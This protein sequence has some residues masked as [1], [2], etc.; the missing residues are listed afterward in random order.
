[1]TQIVLMILVLCFPASSRCQ[2]I[3]PLIGGPGKPGWKFPNPL[4]SEPSEPR[5]KPGSQETSSRQ[6][7]VVTRNREVISF[8]ELWQSGFSMTDLTTLSAC[9]EQD[10]SLRIYWDGSEFSGWERYRTELKRL[11]GA[12]GTMK[13]ELVA[14]EIHMLGRFAWVS[15]S[16]H[17]QL[18][19]GET[20]ST[21]DGLITLILE[22]RRNAWAIQHMHASAVSDHSNLSSSSR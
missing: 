5:N 17:W 8:L 18:W 21:S 16:Y 6:D 12:S 1:M 10:P 15:A 7:S 22:K 3:P 11:V 9:Y 19:L 13:M 20:P 14:P 2:N 4:G